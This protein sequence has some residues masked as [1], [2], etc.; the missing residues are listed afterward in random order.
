MVST[1]DRARAAAGPVARDASCC[2]WSRAR[3][4]PAG[5]A[6]RGARAPRRSSR[7]RDRGVPAPADGRVHRRPHPRTDGLGDAG[8]AAP[9]PGDVAVFHLVDDRDAVQLRRAGRARAGSPAATPPPTRRSWRAL[10]VAGAG[11]AP[12]APPAAAHPR[13]ATSRSTACP[14]RSTA[15]ASSRS[16]TCTA[17]PSR[18]AGA[19]PAGWRRP[20]DRSRPGGG[21]RRS[22]RQRLRVRRRRGAARSAACARA[23]APSRHGQP[24]LLRRRRGDGERARSRGPDGAAQPRRRA[25]PRRR[26]AIYLAG[27]DDTWTRRHDVGRALAARPAGMPAVLLAHDPALFPE[28][29]ARGVD[30]VLSGHTHGGQVAVPL[31]ARKLNLARLITRFTNGVYRSGSPRCT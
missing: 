29:A 6:G 5:A 15:T 8:T 25:A 13:V 18:A 10:V 23:T 26:G 31:L 24:R 27:V 30:L 14:K 2:W 4:R 19:S 3:D 20:T 28:A 9:V 16:P 12:V 21:D 1:N 22:D 17:V 7:P 11:A